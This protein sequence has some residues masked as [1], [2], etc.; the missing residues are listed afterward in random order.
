TFSTKRIVNDNT[1]AGR[2]RHPFAMVMGPDDSLW[3]TER[4]GY[5][6]RMNRHNG[7]KTELLNIRNKVKFTASGGSIKQDGMFGIALHPE[8]FTPGKNFVYTAYT[9]DSSG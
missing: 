6:I 4:R 3:I 8:L 1:A 2:L 5:I 9:Y 7:G